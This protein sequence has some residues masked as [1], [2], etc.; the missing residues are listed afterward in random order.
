MSFRTGGGYEADDKDN[1]AGA[2]TLLGEYHVT[3]QYLCRPR[4]IIPHLLTFRCIRDVLRYAQ[5]TTRS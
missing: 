1:W 2:L 3:D 4:L 5:D